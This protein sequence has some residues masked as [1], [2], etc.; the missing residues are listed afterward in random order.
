[1]NRV[2]STWA[3][4]TTRKSDFAVSVECPSAR[5]AIYARTARVS[6]NVASGNAST[7][8]ISISAR[9]SACPMISTLRART[10][11]LNEEI[12]SFQPPLHLTQPLRIT[13]CKQICLFYQNKHFSVKSR[14][15]SLYPLDKRL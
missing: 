9:A 4:A 15:K 14:K 6:S 13:P 10:P 7:A 12:V 2:R 3:R 1:M 8:P 11:V 5:V